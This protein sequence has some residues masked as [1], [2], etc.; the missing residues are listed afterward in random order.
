MTRMSLML[1][2]AMLLLGCAGDDNSSDPQ[3]T[4]D[5]PTSTATAGN[6]TNRYPDVVDA[7]VTKEGDTWTV[8]ATISSPYD[9]DD[10]YAD[11]FRVLTPDGEVLGVREL[12]HPHPD[13]QPFTRSLTGLEIP[14]GVDRVT[15]EGRDLVNGWG[16][17]TVTVDLP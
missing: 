10:R 8:S 4:V 12:L 14:E 6:T 13:E 9:S 2:V 11:A 1:L 3:A 17:A 16:G 15:V 5:P 7:E